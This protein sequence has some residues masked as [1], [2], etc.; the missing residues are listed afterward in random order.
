[1]FM[2]KKGRQEFFLLKYVFWKKTNLYELLLI[3]LIFLYIKRLVGEISLDIKN[4]IMSFVKI[5]KPD[6]VLRQ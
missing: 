3:K 6:W 4:K 2:P 5:K 1:M